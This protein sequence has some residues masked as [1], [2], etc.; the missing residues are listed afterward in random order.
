MDEE[1]ATKRCAC[2][3]ANPESPILTNPANR[4]CALRSGAAHET[5]NLNLTACRLRHDA[6]AWFDDLRRGGSSRRMRLG[7]PVP[8]GFCS[9]ASG[10]DRDRDG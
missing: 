2:E 7:T 10:A 9:S 5:N 8:R 1:R 3:V 6:P 4:S